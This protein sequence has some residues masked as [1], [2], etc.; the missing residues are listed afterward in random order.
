MFRVLVL[1]PDVQK[2]L[3][4]NPSLCLVLRFVFLMQ[5]P[6]GSLLRQWLDKDGVLGV[7]ST[8]FQLSDNPPLGE[9]SIMATVE[10]QL[11]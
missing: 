2:G 6:R 1:E 8:E 10:V 7:V 4:V 9:W 3:G 11:G 5:D